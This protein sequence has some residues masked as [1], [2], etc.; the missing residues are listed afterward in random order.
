[1]AEREPYFFSP[2]ARSVCVSRVFL[3]EID[4]ERSADRRTPRP[5]GRSLKL[6]RQRKPSETREW[7]QKLPD[8]VL[9]LEEAVYRGARSKVRPRG[10]NDRSATLALVVFEKMPSNRRPRRGQSDLDRAP[11]A[12]VPRKRSSYDASRRRRRDRGRV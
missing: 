12:I 6:F 5:I 2:R 3:R 8:F 11:I 7:Q 9:R 10:A 4:R 1:V